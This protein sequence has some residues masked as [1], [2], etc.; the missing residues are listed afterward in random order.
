MLFKA[1][2]VGAWRV[3]A[4]GAPFVPH[5]FTF[6]KDGLVLTTNPTNV[7]EDSQNLNDSVG[8]GTWR[9]GKHGIV[10]GTFVQLNAFADT[11]LPGPELR[12]TFRVEVDGRDE[13]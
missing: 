12:V 4:E 13:Q 9:K 8:M 6:T 1:S 11:H 10:E 2:I 7:Q 3:D 5:L